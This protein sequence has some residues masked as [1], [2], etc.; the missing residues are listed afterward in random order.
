MPVSELSKQ[1][2]LP[3]LEEEVLKF[4]K[5]NRVYEVITE[6]RRDDPVFQYLDGPPYTTGAIHLGTAWNKIMKDMVL[7]F[8]RMRGNRVIDTP[9][10]DMHGLPIE[11]TVEKEMGIKSKQEIETKIGVDKFIE[12]CQE[13][14]LSN[15]DR[16]TKQFKRLGVWMDWERPYRTLDNQYIEG[17]W[18]LMKRAHERG[19]LYRGLRSIDCCI[20]CET[21]LAK[22]EH[23]F[24]TIEDYSIWVKFPVLGRSKE[25]IVIWT[26]TPWTLPANMAVMVNP[27]FEYVRVRVDDEV[28]ILAKG[29]ANIILQALLNKSYELVEEFK[30]S[31]LKGLRYEHPL[32]D[33]VP[34]QKEFH[35]DSEKVHS[36]VLSEEYV[37]LEQGTGLVHMAPG[38]GPQD[39]EVGE[40][41]GIPI[42]CP[43]TFSGT[44]SKEGGKYAG[45]KVQEAS[46][47]VLTDL[48]RKG[49]LVHQDT[50][51]HEYAHCWRCGSPLVFL[52][53]DQWFLRVSKLRD[54]IIAKNKTIRW[55]P[56]WAGH[57]WFRNWVKNLRD[58]CISRQRY[59]GAPLPIWICNK[60]D[61]FEVIGSSEELEAKTKKPI[62]NFHR[63]W[64]DEITWPCSKCKGTM[65]R[66]RDVLDVWLDSGVAPWASRWATFGSKDF[67]NWQTA[68][69]VIEGKDQISNWF[70][71]LFNSTM[72]VADREPYRN[73][74]MHGFTADEHG[75]PM[76]KSKGTGVLPEEVVEKYGA[77]TLRLYS[78]KSTGPGEDMHFLWKDV[79][80][81]RRSLSIL[82]NV[83]VFATTFMKA[84]GFEPA[85][86]QLKTA[87]LQNEDR[88]ILSQLHLLIKHTTERLENYELPYVPRLMEDFVIQDLSRWYIKLIR[89][90]TWVSSQDETKISAFATLYYVLRTLLAVLAPVLPFQAEKMY[91]ALVRPAESDAPMSVHMLPWPECDETLI[92]SALSQEMD[93]VSDIVEIAQFIRQE[94]GLKLRWPC[95]R[96]VIVPTKKEF[97]LEHFSDVV[98]SQTNV[99]SVEILKKAKDAKLKGKELPYAT[100]Y[101]DITETPEL[102]AERLARDLIRQIQAT[103]KKAGLHVTQ[104]IELYI[105]TQSSELHQAIEMTMD[106][107]T[108]KVGAIKLEV[109]EKLPNVKEITS[110]KITF[111]GNQ[112]QF[113]FRV[114]EG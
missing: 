111:T 36:V 67:D 31:K 107:I 102:Q 57:T 20:R 93:W 4:W 12:R 48:R 42:F 24:R 46:E 25:F 73:V 6:Q 5:E 89:P 71:T 41:E 44:F 38:H 109:S 51:E 33:E 27:E 103:R 101:L 60:C 2:D 62:E 66:V 99:K 15:L 95:L 10:F 37:T 70:N 68:D 53:T 74:F 77:E 113:G 104:Q 76:S 97:N 23:E 1:F 65:T 100:V 88:W 22:R 92:D 35:R 63:P 72:L 39:F 34:K 108:S 28:W 49:L 91:Q 69:F 47:V 40:Q 9:G 21:A 17:T 106:G 52:A 8:Y 54:D 81:T 56:D 18:Y 30:G 16:M 19:F 112:I 75:R 32:L 50:I 98:A 13:F 58:W 84:A 64:I 114:H 59:W 14:A 79:E 94:E 3:S 78:I 105:A 43:V 55:V 61:H 7:R 29:L 11:V 86:Y 96:L 110:G 87:N 45:M 80:D 82:W 90:R 85:S 83:Y 26:T